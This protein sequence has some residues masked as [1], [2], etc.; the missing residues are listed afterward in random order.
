[1][2]TALLSNVSY[3]YTDIVLQLYK[4]TG[5]ELCV[6]AVNVNMLSVEY[7]HPKTTPNISVSLA[8][9]MSLSIPG[10][11]ELIIFGT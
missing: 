1:M 7:F 5:I 11:S 4:K 2:F 6:T 8:V 9:R 3:S 10:E